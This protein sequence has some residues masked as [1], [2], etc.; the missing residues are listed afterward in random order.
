MDNISAPIMI[1]DVTTN[2]H[3]SKDLFRYFNI[4]A[5]NLLLLPIIQRK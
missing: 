2:K 4:K 1:N 3:L 5:H